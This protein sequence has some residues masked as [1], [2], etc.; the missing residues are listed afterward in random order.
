LICVNGWEPKNFLAD[1]G[2]VPINNA[3]YSVHFQ[4]AGISAKKISLPL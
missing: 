3:V 2:E 1:S 4:P